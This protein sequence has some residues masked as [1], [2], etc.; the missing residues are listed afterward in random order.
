VP[1]LLTL[2]AVVLLV[3]FGV[4]ARAAMYRRVS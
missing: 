2:A 3:A 1:L 4:I